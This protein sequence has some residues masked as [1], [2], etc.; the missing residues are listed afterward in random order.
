MSAHLVKRC[1][2]AGTGQTDTLFFG[3]SIGYLVN[4]MGKACRSRDA[5][6]LIIPMGLCSKVNVEKAWSDFV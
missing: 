4:S 3:G 1:C 6:K 2:L 5:W